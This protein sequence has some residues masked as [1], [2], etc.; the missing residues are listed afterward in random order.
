MTTERTSS[1]RASARDGVTTLLNIKEAAS[2][3]RVSE[4]TLRRWI[5]KRELPAARLGNQWRIRPRDLDLFI[6]DRLE[7]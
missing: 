1:A 7:W 5:D 3:L 2:I 4:K 6:K